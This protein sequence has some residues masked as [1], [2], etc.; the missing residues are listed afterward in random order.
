MK[1]ISGYLTLFVLSVLIFAGCAKPVSRCTAPEDNPT[2]HYVIGMELIDQGKLDEAASKLER[3]VYCDDTFAPAHAGLAIVSAL[4]ATSAK[5]DDKAKAV[6]RTSSASHLAEALRSGATSEDEFAYHVASIRTG[7][8]LKE[9]KWL[10]NAEDSYKGVMK[11]KVDEGKLPYYDGRE[12]A[13]YFMGAAYL[14]GREFQQAR[15]RFADVLN[16]KKDGRWNAPADRMWKKTDKIVRAIAGITVGDVGKVIATRASVNR[17]E[18]AALLVDELKINKLFAGRI[19]SDSNAAG[20][21]AEFTPADLVD[22]QF[23]EE[24]LSLMKWNVRGLEPVYDSTTRAYLFKPLLPVTRKEFALVLED[25]IIKLTGDEKISSAFLGH[26][27]SPFHDIA[28][29][30]AWYNS[31]MT[32]TTRSIMETELSGDFRP[33]ALLDGAEAMLAI[34]V[35]KQRLNIY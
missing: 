16:S 3:A 13:T 31:A 25:V 30:A 26:D 17:G 34:R 4:K 9:G 33:D 5:S 21:K 14:E 11:L 8:I 7:T 19:A 27:K 28:P 32:V 29:T 1:N 18:M 23:R 6:D 35:L 20:K 12:S 24:V 2:H 10:R 22:N 15:D